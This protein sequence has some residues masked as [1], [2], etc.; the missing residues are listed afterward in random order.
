MHR[1]NYIRRI[2]FLFPPKEREREFSTVPSDVI[3]I[4]HAARLMTDV[5]TY[6]GGVCGI[7]YES[8]SDVYAPLNL[9]FKEETG[10]WIIGRMYSNKFDTPR[11][12]ALEVL[13]NRPEAGCPNT[14]CRFLFRV[15]VN[16][17]VRTCNDRFRSKHELSID[18]V[19]RRHCYCLRSRAAARHRDLCLG[20]VR[21]SAELWPQV[22]SDITIRLGPIGKR[23]RAS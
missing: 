23:A 13:R 14:F 4:L 19:G 2:V 18:D 7:A 5:D 3:V 11:Q 12:A 15:R 16:G 1:A 21:C 20:R 6:G 17:R 9:A 10:I 22:Y 8:R